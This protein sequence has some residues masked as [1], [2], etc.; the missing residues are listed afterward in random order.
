[1]KIAIFGLGYVGTVSAACLADIG[2]HV[3]GVDINLTKVEMINKGESPIVETGLAE[4]ISRTVAGGRLKATTQAAEALAGA[5][6][7]LI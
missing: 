2:H 7:S 1:M 6:L 5:D 4:L 3:V